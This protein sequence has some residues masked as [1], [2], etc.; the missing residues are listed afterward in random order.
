M[1][2]A[3]FED[4]RQQIGKHEN[5]AQYCK[6]N[7]IELVRQMLFVG[8]YTNITDQSVSVDTKKDLLEL[9]MD[10]GNEKSRFYEEARRA[11]KY[12]IK[13]YVL[14]E[15]G[16]GIKT[17]AD[18]NTW[19]NP[20]L[21]NKKNAMQGTMLVKRLIDVHINYGTEFLFCEKSETGRIIAEILEGNPTVKDR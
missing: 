6:Q 15:H 18:V 16:N 7:G 20:L 21:R 3:I 10:V 19:K 4:T 2:K 14:C 9:V 13:L 1:L 8:D 11:R 5:I 17:L 12:G